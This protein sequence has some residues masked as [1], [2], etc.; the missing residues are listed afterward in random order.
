MYPELGRW[1]NL[2]VRLARFGG[3]GP[4]WA[5]LCGAVASGEMALSG[6][7][8]LA[9]LL[10]FFLV[11]PLWGFLWDHI[12]EVDWH[13]PSTLSSLFPSDELRPPPYTAPNSPGGRLFHRLSRASAWWRGV[14]WP[15]LG[16]EISGLAIALSLTAALA[17]I[18]GLRVVILTIVALSLMALLRW[19]DLSPRLPRAIL[20]AGLAWLVGHGAFGPLSWP[21]LTLAAVYAGAY[22]ACLALAAGKSSLALLNGAQAAVVALLIG[23]K[24]P[25]MAGLV[26]L[27]LLP[28][29]LLQSYLRGSGSAIRYLQRT[30]LFLMAGMMLAALAV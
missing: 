7:A 30:R 12:V 16:S 10:T 13:V 8:L 1:V 6:P 20:E 4:I 5:V 18:L 15:K 23:L 19:R 17:V 28:Q 11:D 21:S 27:T 29:M 2:Q 26:G 22:Y 3:P 9:M 25:L 24:H 14:L